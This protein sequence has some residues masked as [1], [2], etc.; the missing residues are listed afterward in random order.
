[1]KKWD[2]LT[3]ILRENGLEEL[4]AAMY[5][6]TDRTNSILDTIRNTAIN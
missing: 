4:L 5:K 3:I 2:L 1:M 6:D